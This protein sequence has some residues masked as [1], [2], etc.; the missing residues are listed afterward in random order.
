MFESPPGARYSD[1]R[2]IYV[3]RNSVQPQQLDAL[4]YYLARTREVTRSGSKPKVQ[5]IAVLCEG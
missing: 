5:E 4:T 3:D 2:V 1:Q